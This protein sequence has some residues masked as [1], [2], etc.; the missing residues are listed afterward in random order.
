MPQSPSNLIANNAQSAGFRRAWRWWLV[1]A[2]LALGL[3]LI[4]RDPFIGDWDAVDYTVLA[5]RGEPSSMALGRLL[6]VGYNHELWRLAHTVFGLAPEHAH[7]L[8]QFAIIAQA[9]LAAIACFALARAVTDSRQV[10]TLAALLVGTSPAFT[11]YGGQVM[12][13]IPSLLVA[14]CAMLIYWR[15]VQAQRMSLML[16]GAALL[17]A[18]VN[19]RETVAFYGLWLLLA[20]LAAKVGE[21]G[22]K[23]VGEKRAASLSFPYSLTP[24]LPYLVFALCA[25]GPFALWFGLDI[26][27]YRASWYG[28]LASMQ[29][30]TARHPVS[31]RNLGPF[32]GL[33]TVA[34][35][36]LFWLWP[37]ALL[38]EWRRRGFSAAFA[39]GVCGLVATALLF[40]NYSTTINARYFLSGLPALAP[41]VAAF[42]LHILTAL[43]GDKRRAFM[44]ALACVCVVAL[45]RDAFIFRQRA[46]LTPS[47]L[48]TQNY[49]QTLAQIPPDAVILAG[50]QTVA[51]TYWHNLGLGQWE[52]IGTGGGWPGAQLIP[53]IRQYLANGRRVFLDADPRAW[54][55]CGWQA[56]ETRMLPE[57][58]KNFRFR[59]VGQNLLE[60]LSPTA[61]DAPDTADLSRLLP[62]NRPLDVRRCFSLTR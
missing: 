20:P 35:L 40:F 29:L 62:E 4:F 26:G 43:A 6:F 8:F 42:L 13:E 39:L 7:L 3:A 24:L 31:W 9:P 55:V 34:S 56:Q 18:G 38:W 1:P 25:F 33:F 21:W 47:R 15:G 23:G 53:L 30:E 37:A 45:A 54:A 10:A 49:R 48:A 58:E 2:L 14:T 17:G 50:A 44:Y 61:T 28:W 19:L 57:L 51:V 52:T 27:N 32:F 36:P 12:T 59:Q 5:V 41:I 11:I 22:S 16:A 60:L 46:W